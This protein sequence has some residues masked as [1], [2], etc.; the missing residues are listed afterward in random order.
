MLLQLKSRLSVQT[1]DV[2]KTMTALFS[3]AEIRAFTLFFSNNI[4]KNFVAYQYVCAENYE[5]MVVMK[6]LSVGTPLI[7][8]PLA[9]AVEN[10]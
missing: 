10:V 9:N 8:P 2:N 7:P 4:V 1:N 3:V 6:H 5:E